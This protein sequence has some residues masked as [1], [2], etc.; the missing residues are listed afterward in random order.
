MI[1]DWTPVLDQNV[2]AIGSMVIDHE[3]L[4]N[5]QYGQD[6]IRPFVLTMR[7]SFITE[8]GYIGTGPRS[9]E[10][11]DSVCILFGGE[12][13]YIVR[14]RSPSSDEYIF[15][16]NTYVHGIMEGEATTTWKEQKDSQ[17]PKFQERLFKLI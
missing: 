2:I 11:G 8:R 13:R 12:T 9:L 3:R 5:D 1:K 16:G 17:D 15:L 14:P 7:K 10:L 6:I 4:L